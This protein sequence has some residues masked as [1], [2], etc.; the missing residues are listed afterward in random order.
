MNAIDS[1]NVTI[2]GECNWYFVSNSNTK[3][4]VLKLILY[5]FQNSW[6]CVPLYPELTSF[7]RAL[8]LSMSVQALGASPIPG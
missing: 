2:L 4:K 7:Q 6:T 5:A 8:E 1:K 3:E